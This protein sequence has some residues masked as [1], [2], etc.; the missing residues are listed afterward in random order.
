MRAPTRAAAATTAAVLLGWCAPQL[1]AAAACAPPITTGGYSPGALTLTTTT[2]TLPGLGA[3]DY[4]TKTG[5]LVLRTYKL[6]NSSEA[7]IVRLTITD[8]DAGAPVSCTGS[9]VIGAWTTTIC[10]VH[11]K[12]T[13]GEHAT[14]V[15]AAGAISGV[16]VPVTASADAGYRAV[17]PALRLRGELGGRAR[18]G[19]TL[20]PTYLVTNAG[21]VALS[22]VDLG[23]TLPI[24]GLNCGAGTASISTLSSG[25][26]RVCTGGLRADAG[27]RTGLARAHGTSAERSIS[28]TGPGDPMG[29]EAEAATAY[30]GVMEKTTSAAI[31]VSDVRPAAQA[32]AVEP[33]P[34]QAQKVRAPQRADVVA[35]QQGD[36]GPPSFFRRHRAAFSMLMVL[37]VV[38]LVPALRLALRR[39]P[40]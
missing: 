19:A 10:T 34:Q 17:T 28:Q 21:D 33:R 12:A 36:Y 37:L 20:R 23:D 7:T 4:V 2:D 1:A 16:N 32:D 11:F 27:L 31:P 18:V 5:E 15:V 14:R 26:T 3:L 13:A 8:P 35:A 39:R 38:A 30:T 6:T 25:T 40:G 9:D 24:T 29:V 22:N